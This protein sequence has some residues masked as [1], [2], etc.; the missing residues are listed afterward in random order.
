MIILPSGIC[1]F[2]IYADA[3]GSGRQERKENNAYN[4]HIIWHRI[5]KLKYAI[6]TKRLSHK[7][8]IKQVD[9][10]PTFNKICFLWF[11]AFF[12]LLQMS[13]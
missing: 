7:V 8:I 4:S 10:I 2:V 12:V 11:Y 9:F 1:N 3:V 13:C 5:L 6:T